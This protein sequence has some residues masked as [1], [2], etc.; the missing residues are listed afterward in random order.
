MP[1]PGANGVSS[2]EGVL[3]STLHLNTRELVEGD[4]VARI[5]PGQSWAR[6]Y[7]FVNS[8]G[9]AVAGGRFSP[10]G[11][12][13]LLL[14]GGVNFFGPQV[15]WSASTVRNYEIVLADGSVV[16]AN[17]TSRPDLFWALKGGSNNFGIVT[18]FDLNTIKVGKV[19]GGTAVYDGSAL[20][21]LTSATTAFVKAGGGIEDKKTTILPM[22]VLAPSTGAL[23]GALLAFH[24]G[25]SAAPPALAN[26]TSLPT[27]STTVGVRD[28]FVTFTNDTNTEFYSSRESRWLFAT[29]AVKF[30]PGAVELLSEA[31]A[32]G[33]KGGPISAALKDVEK[34]SATM[35]LQPIGK[36]WLRAARQAGGDAIDL[37]PADG[38]F[39]AMVAAFQW[40]KAA[41]DAR[42]N[43][44]ARD[45]VAR[46]DAA[47]NKKALHYPYNYINDA[48][49]GQKVFEFYGK[50]KSLPKLKAIAKK[51]DPQGVFQTLVVG[52]WGL[53]NRPGSS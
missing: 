9:R 22:W 29:A 37:D 35:S 5:G 52:G 27:T 49:Q 20:P 32:P 28:S 24:N 50:G 48:Q 8:R 38:E 26:F 45:F 16:E 53:I 47:A 6:V 42:V 44:A 11:V 12:G 51:Y 7:E 18:R 31:F 1:V 13:G 34:A 41:D 15:G 17:A 46:I 33:G 43:K 39:Y 36:A 19:F 10:V 4:S 14:G 2:P 30:G 23:S 3:I 25:E 21:G 40:E